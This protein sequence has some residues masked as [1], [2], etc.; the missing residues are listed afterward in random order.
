MLGQLSLCNMCY[1]HKVCQKWSGILTIY[2][3][4]SA[5]NFY[6]D[7]DEGSFLLPFYY[8][9]MLLEYFMVAHQR[10]QCARVRSD[11]VGYR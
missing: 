4:V 7:V 1:G 8:I 10:C 9:F 3:L 2:L 11:K 5:I 6:D